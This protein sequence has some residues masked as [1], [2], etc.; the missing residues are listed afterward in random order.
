MPFTTGVIDHLDEVL[1]RAA[2]IRR[3]LDSKAHRDQI[4]ALADLES[5][6]V[7]ARRMLQRHKETTPT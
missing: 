1:R 3:A 2:Q 7:E 4:R 6:A 5:H